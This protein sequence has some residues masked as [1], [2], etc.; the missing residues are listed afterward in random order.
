MDSGEEILSASNSGLHT[1]ATY[2]HPYI[3]DTYMD[4]RTHTHTHTHKAYF[5]MKTKVS[6]SPAA[7][8]VFRESR[9]R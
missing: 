2:M 3:Q 6:I 7:R 5:K 1:E 8:S 4:G 9:K